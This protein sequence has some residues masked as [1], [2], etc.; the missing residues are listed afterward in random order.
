MSLQDALMGLAIVCAMPD[1]AEPT[2]FVG[3]K[4]S[5]GARRGQLIQLFNAGERSTSGGAELPQHR[6]Q[7]AQRELET[8]EV[9]LP[10]LPELT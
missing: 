3:S 7:T 9:T 8:L 4:G 10:G 1:L 2:L 6:V 5:K